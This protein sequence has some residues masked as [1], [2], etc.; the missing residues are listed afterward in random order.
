MAGDDHILFYNALLH[1]TLLWIDQSIETRLIISHY[2]IISLLKSQV[3]FYSHRRQK[4]QKERCCGKISPCFRLHLRHDLYYMD[5]L[6]SLQR[7]FIARVT[8]HWGDVYGLLLDE[9]NRCYGGRWPLSH[10]AWR[11]LCG[12]NPDGGNGRRINP[13][14]RFLCI[15]FCCTGSGMLGKWKGW[16][17][18]VPICWGHLAGFIWNSLFFWD[19]HSQVGRYACHV[20][21]WIYR[22]MSP[23][24]FW[25]WHGEQHHSKQIDRVHCW[26]PFGDDYHTNSSGIFARILHRQ[27]FVA[28]GTWLWIRVR[29][30]CIH[31]YS[32]MEIQSTVSAIK[33]QLTNNE[34]I[35]SWGY[36]IFCYTSLHRIIPIGTTKSASFWYDFL[37]THHSLCKIPV[38]GVIF[39]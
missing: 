34:S 19:I 14:Q 21:P 12:C 11:K 35:A 23:R 28:A 13:V 17:H 15:I 5:L 6:C 10:Y 1:H 3:Q 36:M 26:T 25:L 37:I 38:Y 24:C 33:M 18:W 7:C 31:P 29:K 39:H 27:Y 9:N 30:D 8:S 20:H 22:R 32:E 16:L 4:Q 2:C